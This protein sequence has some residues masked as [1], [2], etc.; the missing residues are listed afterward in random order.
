MKVASLGMYDHPAQQAA[1]D[2]LWAGMAQNLRARGQAD[3]PD[4][5]DRDR[6]VQ[7]IWRDPDLLFGQICGYPYAREPALELQVLALPIYDA[8][9]CIGDTHRS[10]IVAR[11]DDDAETLSDYRDRR[12]AINDRGSNSG[13]NLFR[14]LVAPLAGGTAFFGEVVETGAH[15]DSIRAIVAHRADIAAI[16]AVTYAAL[17]RFEPELT[18]SLKIVAQSPASPTLPFV[19]GR[20]SD[21]RTVDALKSALAGVLADPA[22]ADA[23]ATLFLAGA[24]EATDDR[25]T[26]LLQLQRDASA[27]GYP[28]LR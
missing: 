22:F 21:A 10:V 24:T 12:A 4:R 19:T 25:F 11:R 20:A 5:L 17:D 9:G 28:D 16:D 27:A 3:V 15:R 26:P 1:N 13:T 2:R 6:P 8:P 7:A 14:A 23:R 18:R